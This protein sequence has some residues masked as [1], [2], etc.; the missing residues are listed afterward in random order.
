[1]ENLKGKNCRYD[2]IWIMEITREKK[3]NKVGSNHTYYIYIL[4]CKILR[5][6]KCSEN[7]LKILNMFKFF[8]FYMNTER[9]EKI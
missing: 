7:Y 9:R 4:S 2:C 5:K 6:V 8:T 3:K 1:M